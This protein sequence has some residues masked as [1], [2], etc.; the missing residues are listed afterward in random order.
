MMTLRTY[1]QSV[2]EVHEVHEVRTVLSLLP[3]PGT[4]HK[5]LC[6]A[7]SYCSFK[8]VDH[9]VDQGYRDGCGRCGKVGYN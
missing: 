4:A 2:H 7:R 3:L 5:N 6:Q 1:V 8:V 9:V